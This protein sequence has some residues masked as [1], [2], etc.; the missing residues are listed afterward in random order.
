MCTMEKTTQA[1]V[2]NLL[3]AV[4]SFFPVSSRERTISN[5]YG[6]ISFRIL[7]Q[8]HTC[9]LENNKYIKHNNMNLKA[10]KIP[11]ERKYFQIERK[12][13]DSREQTALEAPQA[14]PNLTGAHE[15]ECYTKLDL[16]N[17]T[18]YD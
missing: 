5:V 3:P 2:V 1:S 6:S 7:N 4:A 18:L 15:Y 10:L 17:N 16:K 12:N 8:Q 11:Y 13:Q 14:N 9:A